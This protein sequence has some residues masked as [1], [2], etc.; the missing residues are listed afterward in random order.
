MVDEFPGL[1]DLV[2]AGE[3]GGVAGDGVEQQPLVGFRA[4]F[5]E[6]GG[7]VEIHFHRLQPQAVAGDFRNHAQR[8]ALVRLDADDEHVAAG[9][10]AAGR[11]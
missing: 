7:V 11:C 8:D 1:L 3:E 9:N 2:A 5:A 10:A 6:A 4:G